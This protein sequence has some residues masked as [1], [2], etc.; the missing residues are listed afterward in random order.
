[1]IEVSIKVTLDPELLGHLGPEEAVTRI[2]EMIEQAILEA[3]VMN[4]SNY[5]VRIKYVPH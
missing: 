4:N 5:T 2:Q 3:P 1:M